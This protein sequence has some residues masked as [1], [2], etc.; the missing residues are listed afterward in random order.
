MYRILL[1]G[2]LPIC[3]T[4][5]VFR[6]KGC[7]KRDHKKGSIIITVIL[8]KEPEQPVGYIFKTRFSQAKGNLEEKIKKMTG[9][10]LALK[11]KGKTKKSQFQGKRRKVKDIFKEEK[12]K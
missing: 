1:Q 10:G 2:V 4:S 6:E 5:F 3:Q 8:N 11:R 7:R 12:K 9:S